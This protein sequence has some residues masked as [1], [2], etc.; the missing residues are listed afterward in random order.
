MPIQSCIWLRQHRVTLRSPRVTL[1]SLANKASNP[2]KRVSSCNMHLDLVKQKSLDVADRYWNGLPEE[3]DVDGEILAQRE[4]RLQIW[5]N[6]SLPKDCDIIVT[7]RKYVTGYDE[8]RLCAI[9]L[10]TRLS[11]PEILQQVLARA[12]RALPAE[13]ERRPL[14]FDVAVKKKEFPLATCTWIW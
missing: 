6:E 7:C 9:F 4:R 8:W 10:L 14:L 12:T 3:D 11:Q 13:G 5:C 1:K 2:V